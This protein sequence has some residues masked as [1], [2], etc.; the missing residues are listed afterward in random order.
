MQAEGGGGSLQMEG[1]K[2]AGPGTFRKNGKD[3]GV[4]GTGRKGPAGR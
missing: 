3:K 1:D 2:V 4:E